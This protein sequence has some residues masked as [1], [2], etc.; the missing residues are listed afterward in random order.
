MIIPNGRDRRA[1]KRSRRNGSFAKRRTARPPPHRSS[2]RFKA[3]RCLPAAVKRAGPPR[4]KIVAT[5]GPASADPGIVARMIQAGMTVARLNLA[6][7]NPVDQARLVRA[8]R[9]AARRVGRPIAVL[10]DVAGP[11]IRVGAL[12]GGRVSLAAGRRVALTTAPAA[13]TA[14]RIPITEPR[15]ALDARPGDPIFLAD[16]TLELRARRIHGTDIECDVVTGGLLLAG[17]GVNVPRTR[18]RMPSLT[19]K[20]RRDVAR[21]V[22]LGVDVLALSFVRR[23]ADIAELRRLLGRRPI[24]VVAKIEQRQAVA[25]LDAIL[26][27]ADGVMVARGDLAVETSLEEVPVLQKRI[28]RRANEAGKPV[29]TA[30]QMLL[31]MVES[32]HPTRAE[33]ADVANAILD[34]S[35]ALMLS[36]ETAS[37]RH[38]VRV[39]ETMARIAGRAEAALDPEAFARGAPR[40]SWVAAAVSEAAV[41]VAQ[42]VGAKAIVTPTHGGATPRFVARLRPPVPVVAFSENARTIQFLNLTWGVHPVHRRRLGPFDATLR[43]AG[44]ELRRLGLLRPGERFVLTAGYPR[45]EASNLLTVQVQSRPSK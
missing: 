45:K 27:A 29:I 31:S 1:P 38:P 18:L 35:D 23:A 5:L 11:K 41:R 8:A 36:E 28:I 44:Q 20:D 16:G 39:V 21:A 37:G 42:R 33:A 10:A 24:P 43:L 15:L 4:T 3:Y 34:G 25:E 32:T 9:V 26:E 22:R 6:H 17:K 19:P 7:G 13:G 40:A 30:T 2:D 12:A 14:E